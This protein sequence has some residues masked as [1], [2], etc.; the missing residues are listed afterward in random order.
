M[1]ENIKKIVDCTVYNVSTVYVK[2]INEFGYPCK[3]LLL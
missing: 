3:E 2:K 1:V